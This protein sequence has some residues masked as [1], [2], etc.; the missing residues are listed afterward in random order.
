[1]KVVGFTICLL[2]LI[3]LIFCVHGNVYAHKFYNNQASI[4]FTFAKR[5]EVEE[6]L[7][8]DK[9]P[10]NK[11]LPLQ[12]SKNADNL[13]KQLVT[14]SKDVTNSS[15]LVNNYNNL[16]SGLNLTTKALVAANLADETLK[17]YG[18]AKGLDSNASSSLLNMS[19]DMIM[20]MNSL[21]TKNVTAHNSGISAEPISP[22]PANNQ[23]SR[24]VLNPT[25]NSITNQANFESSASLA[26]SLNLLFSNNLE[27]AVL[28]NSTGLMPIPMTMKTQSVKELGQG[29]NNLIL[30]LNRH[31]PLEEVSSIVH[32]QI[33]PNLFL[34][35]N[36]K[37][38]GE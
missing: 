38:K 19:M 5:Y 24:D 17:Q 13:F 14:L 22:I 34:A 20:K 18:L 31:A 29:I 37:L 35:F 33:H 23:S 8:S 10:A 12:H 9:V 30:A 16:F 3:L 15:E 28:E 11:S 25:D 36:L 2:L 27:N 6:N 1:M 32:G 4:L 7:S 21:R 26:K